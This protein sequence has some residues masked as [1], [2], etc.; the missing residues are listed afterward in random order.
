MSIEQDYK[1][2]YHVSYAYKYDNCAEF[3]IR[4]DV[5]HTDEL[6]NTSKQMIKLKDHLTDKHGFYSRTSVSVISF[7]LLDGQ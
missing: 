3:T 1:Y 4:D 6:I 5:I 7:Q 2:A